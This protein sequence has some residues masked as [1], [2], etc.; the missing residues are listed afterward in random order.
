MTSNAANKRLFF[1]NVSW[2]FS[3]GIAN[4]VFTT[5]ELIILARILG[6][7]KLGLL[8]LIVAYVKI[9]N[10]FLDFKVWEVA[11]KYVGDFWESGRKEHARSIIKLSYLVDISSGVFAFVVSIVLAELLNTYFIKS[12]NGTVYIVI[13]ALS[14]LVSTANS[15]SQA[16]LRVYDKYKN[17]TF[18]NLFQTSVRLLLVSVALFSGYGI[19]GVLISYVASSFLGFAV[20]Q[21]LVNKVLKRHNLSGWINARLGLIKDKFREIA[22][23]LINTYLVSTLKTVNENNFAIIVLGYFAGKEAA[24]LYKIA[25]SMVKVLSKFTDPVY[26][27]LYPSLVRLYS[28]K[29]KGEFVDLIKYSVKTLMKFTVPISIV[30]LLFTSVIISVFLAKNTCPR[31]TR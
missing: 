27:V 16:I 4:S 28:V 30:V 14:L 24:G 13:Y 15:T 17:I 19:K 21:F 3:G 11:V 10:Q 29:L 25:R 2:L 20:L 22:H 26:Q 23:F 12:E 18:A 1:K 31:K 8:S 5:L 6:V 7:E 9:L